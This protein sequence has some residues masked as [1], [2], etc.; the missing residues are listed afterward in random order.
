MLKRI[1]WITGF[2]FLIIGGA[3]YYYWQQATY[4][5]SWY[6]RP[7]ETPSNA[8]N[9]QNKQE[10]QTI[11]Q[12][13]DQQ[14]SRKVEQS[15]ESSPNPQPRVQ[16]QGLGKPVA[17]QLNEKEFNDL[18]VTQIAEKAPKTEILQAAKGINT[19][20]QNGTLET[21]AVINL[22]NL[23]T[24]DLSQQEKALLQRITQTF[25]A[26]AEKDMYIAIEGK[27]QLTQGRLQFDRNTKVKIGNI[28]LTIEELA[29]R[30]GV[31]SATIEQRL[32]LQLQFN[33]L[34]VDQIQFEDESAVI[35][36]VV[37]QNP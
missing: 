15:L 32:N 12:R 17:I 27:P 9:F 18:V 10:I 22:S 13:L 26:L 7:S 30:L 33:D 23:S 21:G 4:L 35:Q 28:S 29:N 11:R 24:A 8:F 34:K 31:P 2:L 14:V 36:G 16:R 19:T 20:I 37:S 3:A 1:L 6:T 25:P 5:P